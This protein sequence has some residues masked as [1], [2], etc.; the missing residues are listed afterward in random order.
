MTIGGSDGAKRGTLRLYRDSDGRVEVQVR[1]EQ[2]TLWLSQ[3][4]MAALFEKDS[5]T[6]GLHL[7]NIY[8]ERELAE[9]ATTEDSSVVQMEGTRRVRR[10]VRL[11]L[12]MGAAGRRLAEAAK[13]VRATTPGRDSD[14][15][16]S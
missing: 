11:A 15:A 12:D 14:G 2:E 3:R 10:R 7:R 8:L 1:L 13:Q 16:G 9:A 5:D 6:I 4:E